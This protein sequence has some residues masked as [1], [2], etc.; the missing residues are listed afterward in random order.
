MLLVVVTLILLVT[1]FEINGNDGFLKDRQNRQR[2]SWWFMVHECTKQ[3]D[4]AFLTFFKDFEINY[5]RIISN[6]VLAQ[7]MFVSVFF[8]LI[9]V[10]RNFL[11]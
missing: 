3:M 4:E 11:R 8:K 5:S 2:R 6:V 1:S 9:Y 7:E 10:I